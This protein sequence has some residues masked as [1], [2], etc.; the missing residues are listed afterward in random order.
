M[1]QDFVITMINFNKIQPVY[2]HTPCKHSL[3]INTAIYI[4]NTNMSI[5]E[6]TIQARLNSIFINTFYSVLIL[7]FLIREFCR[8]KVI[9][10]LP[11][12]SR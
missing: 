11:T 2:L 4:P 8:S 12:I 9:D 7:Y 1:L 5:C 3:S 6:S 10:K